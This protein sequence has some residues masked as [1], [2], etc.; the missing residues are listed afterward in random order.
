MRPPLPRLRAADRRG[1]RQTSVATADRQRRG[2]RLEEFAPHDSAE[3][4]TVEILRVAHFDKHYLSSLWRWT[5]TEF[6]VGV[7]VH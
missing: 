6:A 3:T 7:P 5:A 1:Y 2:I 4:C